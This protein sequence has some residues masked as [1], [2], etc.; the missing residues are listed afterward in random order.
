LTIERVVGVAL[1][2]PLVDTKTPATMSTERSFP[3]RESENA[4]KIGPVELASYAWPRSYPQDFH[5][6]GSSSG[7]SSTK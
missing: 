2:D 7:E 5:T 1:S 3:A 6:I 4:Q